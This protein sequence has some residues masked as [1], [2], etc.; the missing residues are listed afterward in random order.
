[1]EKQKS[2]S[3]RNTPRIILNLYVAVCSALVLIILLTPFQHVDNGMLEGEIYLKASAS[4]SN[5]Q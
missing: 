4:E 2:D 5:G 1:M 3:L